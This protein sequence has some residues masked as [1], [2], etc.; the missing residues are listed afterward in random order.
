M[1]SQQL[2]FNLFRI[3][4]HILQHVPDETDLTAIGGNDADVCL[5]DAF[6]QQ[7]GHVTN[8]LGR[9]KIS[10]CASSDS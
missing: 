2:T 4:D 8:K 1:I 10:N 6:F 9:Q 5:A 7:L 3:P